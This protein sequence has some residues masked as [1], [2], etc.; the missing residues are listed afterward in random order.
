MLLRS[1]TGTPVMWFSVFGIAA[2]LLCRASRR[3]LPAPSPDL[4]DIAAVGLGRQYPVLMLLRPWGKRLRLV[5]RTALFLFLE[6]IL[7][8]LCLLSF[9]IFISNSSPN[10]PEKLS[11]W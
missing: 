2:P 3:P 1:V 11:P 4:L 6:V 5:P 7:V 8:S 9:R 10:S